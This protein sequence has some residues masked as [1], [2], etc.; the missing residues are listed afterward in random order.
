MVQRMKRSRQRKRFCPNRS[1][2]RRGVAK[3]LSPKI[4]SQQAFDLKKSIFYR[5]SIDIS[6]ELV[7]NMSDEVIT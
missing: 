4:L 5:N 1:L 6:S 2:H 7:Y 3:R